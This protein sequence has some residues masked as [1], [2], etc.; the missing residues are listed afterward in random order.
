[1]QTIQCTCG[2]SRPLNRAHHS[3]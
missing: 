2:T 1:M 3:Q